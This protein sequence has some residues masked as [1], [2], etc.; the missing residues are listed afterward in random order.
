MEKKSRVSF[1]FFFLLHLLFD[2]KCRLI[3]NVAVAAVLETK[4]RYQEHGSRRTDED[5]E[6]TR[7]RELLVE[8]Q[9]PRTCL[10]TRESAPKSCTQVFIRIRMGIMM[11][12]RRECNRSDRV[13]D[14]REGRL[15]REVVSSKL[16]L[17]KELKPSMSTQSLVL[18]VTQVQRPD[19]EHLHVS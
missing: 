11:M 6:R 16:S 18:S 17:Q 4:R 5:V 8:K 3:L 10:S 9:E 14:E 15:S 7:T 2:Y 1:F 19:E 12:Q 13:H